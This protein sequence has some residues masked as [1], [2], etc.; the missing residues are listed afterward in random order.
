MEKRDW[1][2]EEE[3]RGAY[4]RAGGRKREGEVQLYL[5]KQKKKIEQL[6]P[7]Q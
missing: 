3:H 1:K 6:G 4:G 2:F 7:I 5:I